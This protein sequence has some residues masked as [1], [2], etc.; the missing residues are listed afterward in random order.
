MSQLLSTCS[1]LSSISTIAMGI[2]SNTININNNNNTINTNNNNNSINTNNSSNTTTNTSTN[3]N[4]SICCLIED[5]HR[6][7]R[8]A[9]NASYS[10]RIEKQVTQRKLRLTVDQRSVHSYICEHHKQMIQSMRTSAKR[11]RKDSEDDNSNDM[12]SDSQDVDLLALQVNTLRR[13]KKH[14]RIQTRPGLNKPQL[15]EVFI[16]YLHYF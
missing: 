5:G 6:C 11:K 4:Q 1:P 10:K 8:I 16:Y 7:Q 12:E 14:Y 9:G 15:A 2:N 3:S 13:Y